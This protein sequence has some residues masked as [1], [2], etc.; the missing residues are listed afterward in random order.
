MAEPKGIAIPPASPTMLTPRPQLAIQL[1]SLLGQKHTITGVTKSD[2][3]ALR[4]LVSSILLPTLPPPA[5]PSSYHFSTPPRAKGMVRIRR[6]WL[7]T[8][9]VT[10]ETKS[11]NLQVWN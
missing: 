4:R 2:G 5:P 10:P 7:D 9:M 6:E 8:Y 3:S 1:G 11:Y